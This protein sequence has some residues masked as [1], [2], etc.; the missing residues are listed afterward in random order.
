MAMNRQRFCDAFLLGAAA[1]QVG[2]TLH[3][4]LALGFAL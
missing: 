1:G 3:G 2:K 4:G